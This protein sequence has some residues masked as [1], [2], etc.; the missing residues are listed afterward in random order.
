[1]D[2]IPQKTAIERCIKALEDAKNDNEKM[3]ALL[4]VTRIVKVKELDAYSTK[5]IYEAVGFEFVNRLFATKSVPK[6]CHQSVYL[7]LALTVLA[8]FASDQELAIHPHM[9]NKIQIVLDIILKKYQF[10]SDEREDDIQDLKEDCYA[11]LSAISCSPEGC[12][13]LANNGVIKDL[14]TF[15]ETNME[16][17]KQALELLLKLLQ[18]APKHPVVVQ[19]Y[20]D[21]TRLIDNLAKHFE[22]SPT[23]IKFTLCEMLTDLLSCSNELFLFIENP[24][25]SS[26]SEVNLKLIRKGLMDILQSKAADSQKAQAISLASAV[27]DIYGIK[28]TLS[29]YPNEDTIYSKKFLL[30]LV[31]LVSVE[32]NTFYDGTNNSANVTYLPCLISCFNIIE[33]VIIH[34]CNSDRLDQYDFEDDS[35]TVN[36]SLIIKLHSA[37]KDCIFGIIQFLTKISQEKK[38][39]HTVNDVIVIGCV[40]TLCAWMSEET[41]ALKDDFS[42]VIPFLLTL[43]KQ[44]F[45][46]K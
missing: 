16:N 43:A 36:S 34:L 19:H 28:W 35:N 22:K 24:A 25:I 27:M 11:I 9:T 15:I 14:L 23:E 45:E 29:K 13:V 10:S 3:A 12:S 5:Q 39:S 1:M 17:S 37:L 7:S 44:S 4:L 6:G 18:T 21:I 42:R 32:M 26:I 40:R 8:C 2:S 30:L 38:H 46:R 41:L 31:S 20:E 33:K